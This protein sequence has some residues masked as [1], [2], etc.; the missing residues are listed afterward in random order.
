MTEAITQLTLLLSSWGFTPFAGD[1]NGF[2]LGGSGTDVVMLP[3]NHVVTNS[4]AFS[5][6]AKGFTDNS[7]TDVFTLTRNTAWK[8][9][10]V[11][12]KIAAAT[13][14]LK[15][16]IAAVNANA[17]TTLT[18]SQTQSGNSWNV[19]STWNNATFKSVSTAA[20]TGA[21]QSGGKVVVS[22]FL[23][24]VSGAAIGLQLI[25]IGS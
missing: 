12:F 24:P 10:D 2:K 14:T 20:I 3:A 23:L 18:G 1:G 25:G 13:A 9:G 21:R 6:A 11:G 8:N 7:Q 19:G 16:N 4:I 17:Q 5:N 15:S 22:N